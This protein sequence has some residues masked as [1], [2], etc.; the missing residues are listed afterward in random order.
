M[1][2]SEPEYAA[3]SPVDVVPEGCRG[4]ANRF[5]KVVLIEDDEGGDVDD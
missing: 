1:L 4:V 3:K 2:R 5:L